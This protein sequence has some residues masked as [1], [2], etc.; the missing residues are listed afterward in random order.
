MNTTTSEDH[1]ICDKFEACEFTS[2]LNSDQINRYTSK[3]HNLDIRDPY[4]LPEQ[5]FSSVKDLDAD[6]LPD[7]QYP[8]IYNYLINYPSV[9]TGD[10]LRAYKSLESY[11]FRNSGFVN[12]PLLWHL[13]NKQLFLIIARVS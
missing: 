11:R 9:F 1:I 2:N 5:L 3:L 7:L 10:A 6:K 8:D 13:P 4:R 12:K